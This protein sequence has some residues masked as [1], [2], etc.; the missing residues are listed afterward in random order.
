MVATSLLIYGNA[1]ALTY[2]VPLL[3]YTERSSYRGSFKPDGH[4]GFITMYTHGGIDGLTTQ[5]TNTFLCSTWDLS[6]YWFAI[7]VVSFA[8]SP[9]VLTGMKT[10]ALMSLLR[11]LNPQ[12]I[13]LLTYR[14]RADVARVE[15]SRVSRIS[16]AERPD[17]QS[18]SLW[19]NPL[20]LMERWGSPAA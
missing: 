9:A 15:T 4:R 3:S 16:P 20:L 17:K 12:C 11:Y 18:S 6:W 5:T 10:S 13:S 14:Y 19:H 2:C 7:R 8:W 1:C